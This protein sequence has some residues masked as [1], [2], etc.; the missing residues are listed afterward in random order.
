MAEHRT[1]RV[2][3]LSPT[4]GQTDVGFEHPSLRTWPGGRR[5][6]AEHRIFASG[7]RAYI[8]RWWGGK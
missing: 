2:S 4:E 8:W 6:C 3:W 5:H 1:H 7:C